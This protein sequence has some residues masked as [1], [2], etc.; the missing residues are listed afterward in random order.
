M[1]HVPHKWLII[2][3][4]FQEDLGLWALS[5]SWPGRVRIRNR[6][7]R[8]SAG[9]RDGWSAIDVIDLPRAHLI[10]GPAGIDIGIRT[11]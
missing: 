3:M 8:E 11:L 9:S 6:D 2:L 7:P 5:C 4:S 1:Q 10:V